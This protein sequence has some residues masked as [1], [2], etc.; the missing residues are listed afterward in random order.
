M[1]LLLP[2]VSKSFVDELV[3][4]HSGLTDCLADVLSKKSARGESPSELWLRL[5]RDELVWCARNSDKLTARHRAHACDL[6]V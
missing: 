6:F 1:L 5:V 4:E 2:A 3:A